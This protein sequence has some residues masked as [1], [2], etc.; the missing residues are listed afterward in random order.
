MR[1]DSTRAT[2][3]TRTTGSSPVGD[4]FERIDKLC[5]RAMNHIGVLSDFQCE[6]LMDLVDRLD[7][8]G[9]RTLLSE[10]QRDVIAGI[11]TTL[12]KED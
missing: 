10:K 11:E 9:P 4:D 12:G 7:D 1:S 6:F 5:G 8:H 3:S 2:G